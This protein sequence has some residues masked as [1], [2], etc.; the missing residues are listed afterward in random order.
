MALVLSVSNTPTIFH[1][2]VT[3]TGVYFDLY[4]PAVAFRNR[5]LND[6][7]IGPLV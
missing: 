4:L 7:Q 3:M 6:L 5:A 1:Q 2:N